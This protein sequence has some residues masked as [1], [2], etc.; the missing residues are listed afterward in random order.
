MADGF[1]RGRPKKVDD[2]ELCHFEVGDT[3]VRSDVSLGTLVWQFTSLLVTD[4]DLLASVACL[5]ETD[6]QGW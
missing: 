4:I 3:A 5:R 1:G 6:A 2:R